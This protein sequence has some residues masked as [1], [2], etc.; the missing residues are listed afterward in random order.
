MASAYRV[1]TTHH[2]DRSLRSIAKRNPDIVDTY[3]EAITILSADPYNRERRYHIRKL[4]NIPCG[5]GQ[6]RLRL[7]RWRFRY[8]VYEREVTLH[9]CG[10]RR[11]DTY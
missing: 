1:R 2:F 3:D 4:E 7:R 6:Y 11:E 9:S 10:L 8:D 5:Q